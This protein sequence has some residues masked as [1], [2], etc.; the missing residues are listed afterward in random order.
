MNEYYYIRYNLYKYFLNIDDDNYNWY[1]NLVILIL[2]LLIILLTVFALILMQNISG[3]TII[4]IIFLILF[5]IASYNLIISL[6]S[7]SDNETL[8]KY[9]K[10][11]DLRNIIF[12]ENLKYALNKYKDDIK[13]NDIEYLYS[14]KQ[15]VLR[16]I[17]NTENIYGKEADKLFNLSLNSSYDLLKYF[18]L[19]EYID[20]GYY[21]RLYINNTNFIQN[22]SNYIKK[23]L[24]LSANKSIYY[25]DLESLEDYPQQQ[26]ELFKYLNNKY[27]KK[28]SF[29]SKNIFTADFNKKLAKSI[30]N[31][32]LNIYYYIIISLLLIILLLHGLFVYFNYAL[33]YIYFGII[34]LSLIIMYYFN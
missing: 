18:D 14:N 27:N 31:Y 20:K 34:I 29:T 1:L 17:N 5:Y 2:Y 12:K 9:Q 10:F 24:T 19:N 32:K 13:N 3:F 26:S 11:Y 21:N 16:N 23:Q 7:I 30:L 33:T 25:I 8:I 6:K 22:N 15:T 4:Y 28:L